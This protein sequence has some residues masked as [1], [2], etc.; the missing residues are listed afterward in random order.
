MKAMNRN[1]FGVQLLFG[2]VLLGLGHA[3]MAQQ[4]CTV[5]VTVP[6]QPVDVGE[7]DGNMICADWSLAGCSID[8]STTPASCTIFSGSGD[9]I[10]V[11]AF[12][13]ANGALVWSAVPARD[14]GPLVDKVILDNA[15]GANGCLQN[16]KFDGTSGSVVFIKSNGIAQNIRGAS[17]CADNV[18]S[19]VPAPPPVAEPLRFCSDPTNPD[20][21]GELDQTG[22]RC[23]VVIDP[24]TGLP[25]IGPDGNPIQKPV[26]VCNLEKDKPDWGATDGSDVCCQC[27]VD[28]GTQ[29]AC[30]VS[31]YN[32]QCQRTT[33]VDLTQSVE[34]LFFRNDGDPCTWK[35]TSRGWEQICW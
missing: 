34:L 23:P 31:P 19:D 12:L 24:E 33:T 15:A 16:L 1:R 14:D 2:I 26:V 4:G 6:D 10:T 27:G 29:T 30:V 13:D 8:P 18:F 20:A 9:E 5:S 35:R 25:V 17:W 3:A 21:I 11:T 7:F 32:P 28:P 22:I